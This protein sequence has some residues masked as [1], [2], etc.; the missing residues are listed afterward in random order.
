MVPRD[1]DS[2]AP[3][4]LRTER[5]RVVWA[6]FRNAAPPEPV[7]APHGV[8]AERTE[9]VGLTAFAEVPYRQLVSD[10]QQ[11]QE[12]DALSHVALNDEGTKQ[13]AE[14]LFARRVDA[15]S[16]GAKL[17][18][19][20]LV[21]FRNLIRAAELGVSIEVKPDVWQRKWPATPEVA[22]LLLRA[23]RA[24]GVAPADIPFA[25]GTLDLYA[26]REPAPQAP[27]R[28]T[29]DYATSLFNFYPTFRLAKTLSKQ[30]HFA[31]GV[32]AFIHSLKLPADILPTVCTIVGTVKPF[33]LATGLQPLPQQ[34][35]QGMA[36][37]P[38]EPISIHETTGQTKHEDYIN[39][40]L[41]NHYF[42][43]E[44]SDRNLRILNQ[45]A[46]PLELNSFLGR[47]RE[48][49]PQSVLTFAARR[50]E[51]EREDGGERLKNELHQQL[52]GLDA[53]SMLDAFYRTP[54]CVPALVRLARACG[55]DLTKV[56]MAD[57][58]SLRQAATAL[59]LEANADGS[60]IPLT[61]YHEFTIHEGPLSLLNGDARD[62]RDLFYSEPE[63]FFSTW[64][65]DQ[66]IENID[67]LNMAIPLGLHERDPGAPPV[68]T[69]PWVARWLELLTR[70]YGVESRKVTSQ[71]QEIRDNMGRLSDRYRTDECVPGLLR[72][73]KA[74][75][76][77]LDSIKMDDNRTTLRERATSLGFAAS[78][79]T[80]STTDQSE[81]QE[82][83]STAGFN[84]SVVAV[85]QALQD[86][87]AADVVT[88]P[89]AIDA[90]VTQLS[91]LPSSVDTT[92]LVCQSLTNLYF[93]DTQ[94]VASLNEAETML[95][96]IK[97]EAFV[98]SSP[99]SGRLGR[100]HLRVSPEFEHKL[101]AIKNRVSLLYHGADE[102]TLLAATRH[103]AAEWL[104]TQPDV[105]QAASAAI[106]NHLMAWASSRG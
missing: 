24:F 27:R 65:S 76:A 81:P 42:R 51:L 96:P 102:E 84:E 92:A 56:S 39:S 78:Q 33:A 61:R 55:V 18:S 4:D 25:H 7:L 11:G 87:E 106:M 48:E 63:K 98:D 15:S 13:L 2:V 30:H 54:A 12:L 53:S 21:L 28:S 83:L 73:A 100:G 67:M 88:L 19:A 90:A 71:Q 62:F 14:T 105:D 1:F 32:E 34:L 47:L 40:H 23:A 89:T 17:G 43:I 101:T 49:L 91:N 86:I 93:R 72:L 60:V 104:S 26:A 59:G 36:V 16:L 66:N 69:L 38:A 3:D 103:E 9:E 31:L 58:S 50:V 77:D 75:N 85:T 79:T 10:L 99:L 35:Y 68:D 37:V 44:A 29:F 20:N 57:N 52:I 97:A 46:A 8:F 6:S 45:T 41:P 95:G 70:N 64:A 94:R 22:A 74:C 82:Q 80:A 5:A